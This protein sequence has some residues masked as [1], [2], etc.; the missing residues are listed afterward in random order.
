MKSKT[1]EK[2]IQANARFYE[3]LPEMMDKITGSAFVDD[4]G[5]DETGERPAHKVEVTVKHVHT[6]TTASGVELILPPGT[7]PTKN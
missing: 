6:N 7:D 1:A 5:V 4:N 3:K 2:E